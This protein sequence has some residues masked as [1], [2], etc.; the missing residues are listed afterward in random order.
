ME[1]IIDI[2]NQNRHWFMPGMLALTLAVLAREVMLFF[3]EF[4]REEGKSDFPGIP[5]RNREEEAG[6]PR[7]RPRSP[8]KSG[9]S[10][11]G[12]PS[13]G[14]GDPIP[15]TFSEYDPASLKRRRMVAAG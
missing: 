14:P 8:G 4:S 15:V 1:Q 5:A 10:S 7:I 12:A 11:G 2:F 13:T 3:R 6:M 9:R